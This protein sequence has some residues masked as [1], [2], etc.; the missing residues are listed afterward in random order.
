[1]RGWSQKGEFWG[2]HTR[3]ELEAVT[4]VEATGG[5]NVSSQEWN[6]G[7]S[8]LLEVGEI[9]NGEGGQENAVLQCGKEQESVNNESTGSSSAENDEC[10]PVSLDSVMR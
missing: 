7:D 9:R 2:Y 6:C 1:M 5:L 8:Y 3:S 4:L 10:L